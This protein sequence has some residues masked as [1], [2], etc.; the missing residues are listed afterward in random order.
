MEVA[1]PPTLRLADGAPWPPPPP[2]PTPRPAPDGRFPSMHQC[3]CSS[4]IPAA[5]SKP[6]SVR[7]TYR[8]RN[9]VIATSAVLSLRVHAVCPCLSSSTVPICQHLLSPPPL[10]VHTVCPRLSPSTVPTRSEG[11]HVLRLLRLLPDRSRAVVM[12]CAP[13]PH[14]LSRTL[15]FSLAEKNSPGSTFR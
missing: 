9:V 5:L 6:C 14:K 13:V 2:P 12:I 8:R 15:F 11:P 10:N 7:R 3:L 1:E 4:Q